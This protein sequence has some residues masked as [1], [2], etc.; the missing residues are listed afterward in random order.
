MEKHQSHGSQTRGEEE[1][2]ARFVC[3]MET[4]VTHAH[5]VTK[6]DLCEIE[7]RVLMKLSELGNDLSV[8]KTT[9]KKVAVEQQTRYDALFAKYEALLVSMEDVEVPAEIAASMAEIKADLVAFDDTIP[10]TTP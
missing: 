5:C 6:H 4:L 9:I 1:L 7:A 3:A 8:V 2:L 10:E